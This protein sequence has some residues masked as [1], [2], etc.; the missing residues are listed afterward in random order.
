MAS[1]VH[2]ACYKST[3]CF[4]TPS[5]KQSGHSVARKDPVHVDE[6]SLARS[7]THAGKLDYF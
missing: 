4:V 5:Q 6:E 1:I 2:D 7:K 3:L